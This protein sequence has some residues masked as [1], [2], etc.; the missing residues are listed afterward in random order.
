MVFCGIPSGLNSHLMLGVKYVGESKYICVNNFLMYTCEYD[1]TNDYKTRKP[2]EQQL[3]IVCTLK[4]SLVFHLYK[5][6]YETECYTQIM[7][8]RY[9]CFDWLLQGEHYTVYRPLFK[10]ILSQSR[11]TL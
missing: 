10:H 8:P 9:E 4:G 1:S 7:L 11:S 2:G 6:L 5:I 3:S